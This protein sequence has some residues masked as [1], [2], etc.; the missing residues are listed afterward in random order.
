VMQLDEMTQQ[1]AA[2][3]EQATAASQSMAEQAGRLDQA[4][5]R[6]RLHDDDG[7][8]ARAARAAHAA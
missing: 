5:R 3:V 8:Q 2:L 1:N 4:M 7:S 6:Y